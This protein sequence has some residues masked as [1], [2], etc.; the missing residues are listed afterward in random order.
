MITANRTIE[1]QADVTK[2]IFFSELFYDTYYNIARI[3]NICGNI[4]ESLEGLLLALKHIE[5]WKKQQK[6][7]ISQID[8]LIKLTI[9]P[10][11]YMNICNA[12]IYLN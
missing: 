1:D 3:Q 5:F 7:V 12:Q 2:A 11:L 10:E 6:A 8:D 9:V 4:E